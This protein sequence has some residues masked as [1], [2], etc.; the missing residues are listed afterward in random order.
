MDSELPNI[1]PVDYLKGSDR[2]A[3]VSFLSQLTISFTM[4]TGTLHFSF[5]N[6]R[7]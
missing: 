4:L 1:I 2:L 6:N 3:L 5:V 7:L